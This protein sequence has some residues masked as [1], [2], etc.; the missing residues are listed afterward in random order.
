MR[1]GHGSDFA[2]SVRMLRSLC[3]GT[4][5]KNLSKHENKQLNRPAEAG[6]PG[7]QLILVTNPDL[8]GQTLDKLQQ[9]SSRLTV[10]HSMRLFIPWRAHIRGYGAGDGRDCDFSGTNSQNTSLILFCRQLPPIAVSTFVCKQ[11][12]C[13]HFLSLI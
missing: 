5:F 1:N 9:G 11:V 3:I 4:C 13:D 6:S 12:Q 8:L 2:L 7:L 10:I